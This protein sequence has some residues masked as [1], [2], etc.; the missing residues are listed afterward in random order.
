MTLST[1]VGRGDAGTLPDLADACL[2]HRV[3]L[4]FRQWLSLCQWQVRLACGCGC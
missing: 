2:C 1:E 4:R 3:H